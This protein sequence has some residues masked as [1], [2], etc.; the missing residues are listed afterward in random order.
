VML[1]PCTDWPITRDSV[2]SDGATVVVVEV[3]VDVVVGEAVVDGGVDVVVVAGV[4]VE[5]VAANVAIAAGVGALVADDD[6][7]DP[8]EH[9]N[10]ISGATTN[11]HHH[12]CLVIVTESF[13]SE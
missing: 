9:D 3:L 2:T 12:A 4:V 1:R 11:A 8:D 6:L 10:I 13:N 7:S 5:V